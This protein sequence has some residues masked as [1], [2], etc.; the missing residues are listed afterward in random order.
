MLHKTI[1]SRGKGRE[2]VCIKNGENNRIRIENNGKMP[3]KTRA[4]Q[5]YAAG[6]GFFL[7]RN[8][9]NVSLHE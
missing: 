8:P 3:V 4:V 6:G 5:C 1:F 2:P 9:L 7:Q